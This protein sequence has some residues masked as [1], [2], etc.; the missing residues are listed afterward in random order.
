MEVN[1]WLTGR[2][3]VSLPFTDA[4]EP[5]GESSALTERIVPAVMQH[6]RERGWRYLECRGGKQVFKAATASQCFFSHELSLFKDEEH[7]FARCESATRRAI[8]KAQKLGVTVE[9]SQSLEAV[10]LFYSLHCQTRKKHGVP[11]Q[12]FDFFCNIHKHILS[13]NLGIVVLARHHQELVAA[14]VY[15]HFGAQA[16][17]KYGASDESFQELRGNNLVMWEAIKWYARRG[18]KVLHLGRT[19]IANEGL[20]RF[21]LGWGSQE[22]GLEYVR[23]DLRKSRFVTGKD[24]SVG[25]YNRAFNLLPVG[26]LRTIG[27]VL[28]R[29]IA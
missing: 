16:I 29:H 24:E 9:V 12:P 6:G 19:S 4:C 8:R 10:R 25:W 14:A 27:A 22:C 23:Y 18:T 1:S 15:F 3:G 11:P 2:R 26:V 17:Y 7:L 20:R 13:R 21:K 28:Y 5:L